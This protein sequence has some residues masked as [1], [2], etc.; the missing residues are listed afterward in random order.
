MSKFG[1]KKG[2]A[3][4]VSELSI[5]HDSDG[6]PVLKVHLDVKE[7]Y[8]HAI[9]FKHP[10]MSEKDFQ[11]FM[12]SHAYFEYAMWYGGA[13]CSIAYWAFHHFDGVINERAYFNFEILQEVLK[14]A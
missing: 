10:V 1:K 3:F 5:M 2:T 14:N 12:K 13:D 9:L 7:V 6:V 4:R 11:F 8:E